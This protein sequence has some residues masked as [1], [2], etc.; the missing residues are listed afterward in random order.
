MSSVQA[1]DLYDVQ[2][3]AA[4]AA[5]DI[6]GGESYSGTVDF[7]VD[8]VSIKLNTET[9][10]HATAQDLVAAHRRKQRDWTITIETK[11]VDTVFQSFA[12]NECMNFTAAATTRGGARS[13]VFISCPSGLIG[14][15]DVV[16]DSP[17]TYKIEIHAHGDDVTIN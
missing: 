3:S 12:N 5:T 6:G 17:S 10:N 16:Y 9:A 13:G 11:L 2:F 4:F 8:K 7:L 15:I 1:L 14:D